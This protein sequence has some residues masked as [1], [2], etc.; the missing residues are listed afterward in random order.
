MSKQVPAAH[1]AIVLHAFNETAKD[2]AFLAIWERR[3]VILSG[4][5]AE[6]IVDKMMNAPPNPGQGRRS[7]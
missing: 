5:V 2:K 1:A 7:E 6:Q 4:E 3:W